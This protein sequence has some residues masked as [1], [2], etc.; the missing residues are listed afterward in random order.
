[1]KSILVMISSPPNT[2]NA[3]RALRLAN[4]F[5]EKGNKVSVFLLQDGVLCALSKQDTSAKALLEKAM[6]AGAGCYVLE[7]DLVCRGFKMQDGISKVRRSDYSELVELMM[8]RND[9]VLGCF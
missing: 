2:P 1:M 3:V 5:N 6:T 8:E 4:A 7:E 9:L